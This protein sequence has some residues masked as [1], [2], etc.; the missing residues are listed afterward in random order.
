MVIKGI[1]STISINGRQL[2]GDFD[3]ATYNQIV[4]DLKNALETRPNQMTI[5]EVFSVQ[6]IINYKCP[7][8]FSVQDNPTINQT[9]K[10]MDG[11]CIQ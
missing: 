5:N 8:G 9:E 4:V 6:D 1:D 7:N 11:N 3:D 2:K 10:L